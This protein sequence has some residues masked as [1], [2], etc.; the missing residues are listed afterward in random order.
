[1]AVSEITVLSPMSIGFSPGETIAVTVKVTSNGV[2][3]NNAQLQIFVAGSGSLT[4]GVT[5]MSGD[6]PGTKTFVFNPYNAGG[7]LLYGASFGIYVIFDGIIWC[8]TP[9][10]PQNYDVATTPTIVATEGGVQP[11]CLDLHPAPQCIGNHI[12]D[13]VNGVW[14]D[15][16]A[17]CGVICDVGDVQNPT[18]CPDGSIVYGQ[19]CVDNAWVDTGDVCPTCLELHPSAECDGSTNTYW[20][21][22]GNAFVDTGVSCDEPPPLPSPLPWEVIIVGG[23]VGAA[24]LAVLLVG[25]K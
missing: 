15:T 21:C 5:G 8:P 18:T 20:N 3:L 4:G 19:E 16:G 2:P 17:A 13:C 24:V 7:G 11:T 9:P 25:K 12:W 1:M 14:V 6:G 23:A 22:V 10:C